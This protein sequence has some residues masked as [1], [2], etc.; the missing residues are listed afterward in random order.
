MD[1]IK[2]GVRRDGE[3]LLQLW[4]RHF[5]QHVVTVN[6][7]G[8]ILFEVIILKLLFLKQNWKQDPNYT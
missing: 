4:D 5:Q 7:I 8:P 1:L 3:H 2:K 6:K